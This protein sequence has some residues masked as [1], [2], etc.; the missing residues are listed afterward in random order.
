[1]D[2]LGE[3]PLGHRVEV[4]DDDRSGHVAHEDVDARVPRA[5]LRDQV[6]G[7]LVLGRV[8]LHQQR[9]GPAHR[10]ERAPELVLVGRTPAVGEDGRGARRA[11]S[12]AI[13]RPRPRVPPVTRTTFDAKLGSGMVVTSLRARRRCGRP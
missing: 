10:A 12:R 9:L 4:T 3:R 11:N 7:V 8:G 5:D 1:V 2:A 6:L 13:V